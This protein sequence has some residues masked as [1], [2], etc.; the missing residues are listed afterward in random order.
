[1]SKDILQHSIVVY[2]ILPTVSKFAFS[3]NPSLLHPT[4]ASMHTLSILSMIRC[5]CCCLLLT[6]YISCL[7][8][9]DI[10]STTYLILWYRLGAN[11]G[12]T[13]SVDDDDDDVS[14]DNDVIMMLIVATHCLI[15]FFYEMDYYNNTEEKKSNHS[16]NNNNDKE[17]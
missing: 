11:I 6:T 1:M 2:Y 16:A 9:I 10:Y 3:I 4:P 17:R 8:F 7:S 15:L 5:G 13:D 12:S 14:G